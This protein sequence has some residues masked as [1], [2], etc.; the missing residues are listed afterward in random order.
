MAEDL[1]GCPSPYLWSAR[2]FSRA[3]PTGV[4]LC[5]YYGANCHRAGRIRGL[6]SLRAVAACYVR[7][8]RKFHQGVGQ[9]PQGC[10]AL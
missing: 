5:G 1:R 4:G 10:H 6:D 9:I 7:T 3:G 8:S 2:C